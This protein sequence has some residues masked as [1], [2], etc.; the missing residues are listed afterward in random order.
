MTE[1]RDLGRVVRRELIP[2]AT[3]HG[4]KTIIERV[5]VDFLKLKK[6]IYYTIWTLLMLLIF[7]IKS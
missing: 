7:K 5:V 6:I 1:S 2:P 3:K 4:S